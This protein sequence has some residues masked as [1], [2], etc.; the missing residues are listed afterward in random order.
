M[1]EVKTFVDEIP[2]VPKAAY[3]D[4]DVSLSDIEVGSPV[5]TT[6]RFP[7]PATVTV[8]SA[9]LPTTSLV[10]MFTQPGGNSTFLDTVFAQKISLENAFME[11]PSTVFGIVRVLNISFHKAVTVRWTTDGWRSVRETDAEYVAGSSQGGTD[12]FSFKLQFPCEELEVGA[13]LQF[14]LRYEC[15]GEFWDSNRGNNYVFQVHIQIISPPC[16]DID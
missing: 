15:S 5:V 9:S 16:Y 2:C 6:S 14:C 8:T 13:K 3:A 1:S 7:L 10:P 11:G 12:K 4:L